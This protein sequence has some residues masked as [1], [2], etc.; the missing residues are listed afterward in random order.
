MPLPNCPAYSHLR[1]L[2]DSPLIICSIVSGGDQ[3]KARAV[4]QYNGVDA[5]P[6]LANTSH[7]RLAALGGCHSRDNAPVISSTSG[8]GAA[9]PIKMPSAKISA[10]A[11]RIS[12]HFEA[13]SDPGRF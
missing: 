10:P 8:P 13:P 2:Q 7:S 6:Q 11:A 12:N 3:F 4:A 9:R 5:A 1:Q